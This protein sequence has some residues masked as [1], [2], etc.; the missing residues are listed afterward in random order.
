V[1]GGG[2]GGIFSL[3]TS[4]CVRGWARRQLLSRGVAGRGLSAECLVLYWVS[5]RV[6]NE[7]GAGHLP[8]AEI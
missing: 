1:G 4:V 7:H 8:R 3:A 5:G 2:G 6:G